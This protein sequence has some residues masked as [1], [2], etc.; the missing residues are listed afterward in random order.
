MFKVFVFLRYYLWNNF[1]LF[2]P[3]VILVCLNGLY[4]KA[5]IGGLII[6]IIDLIVSI[7][8]THQTIKITKNLLKDSGNFNDEELEDLQNSLIKYVEE[9]IKDDV[10]E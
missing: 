4:K 8:K 5:L 6:L 2:I 3:G 10:E 1:F 7:I 9:K